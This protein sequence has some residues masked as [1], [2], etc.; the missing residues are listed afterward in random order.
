[1]SCKPLGY[2][3]ECTESHHLIHAFGDLLERLTANEKLGLIAALS[4]WLSIDD[5][6]DSH[7]TIPAIAHTEMFPDG[8]NLSRAASIIEEIRPDD[9]QRLMCALTEQIRAGVFAE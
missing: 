3:V 9:A 7:W 1:M 2:Y 5:P 4:L 6:E 8:E